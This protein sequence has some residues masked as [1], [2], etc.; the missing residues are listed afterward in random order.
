MVRDLFANMSSSHKFTAVLML[1]ANQLN[2]IRPE[3]AKEKLIVFRTVTK[4]VSYCMFEL[5]LC[6]H[7]TVCMWVHVLLIVYVRACVCVSHSVYVPA[8]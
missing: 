7:V 6:V 4:F 1:C 5:L 2:E 8:P 3:D